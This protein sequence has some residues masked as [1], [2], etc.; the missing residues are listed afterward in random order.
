MRRTLLSTTTLATA[1][2]TAYS[3]NASADNQVINDLGAVDENT[4][5]L[6]Q[7]SR[8]QSDVTIVAEKGDSAYLL[9]MSQE[10]NPNPSKW[11]SRINDAWGAAG[12]S[13]IPSA[14]PAMKSVEHENREL[15]TSLENSVVNLIENQ[16]SQFLVT[17]TALSTIPKWEPFAEFVAKIGDNR[18]LGQVDLFAPLVQDGSSMIFSNIRGTFS[19]NSI[20][21]GNFGLGYRQIVPGGFFGLDSIFG[22]YGF[23]DIRDTERGNTFRQAT[24][25][26][27]LITESLEF[28]V[29]G[30][31][32]E[33]KKFNVGGVGAPVGAIILNGV[34]VGIAG[35]G[36]IEQALPGFDVEAG[37]RFELSE[38]AA[39]RLNAGY[40]RFE[41]DGTRVE[42]GMARAELEFDDPF[43]W[44]GAKFSI[45]GEVRDDNLRGTQGY[46]LARL[47]IPLQAGGTINS[48]TTDR[49]ELQGIDRFMTR[50]IY[51]DDDIVTTEVVDPNAFINLTDVA[52]GETLQVFHVAETPQ[53]V[54]DCS[55]VNN[56]CTVAAAQALAGA[57]DTFL[58]VDVAGNI[59]SAIAL[60]AD[61]QK[62][63]GSGNNGAVAIPMTD[64]L[65][66]ILQLNNLGGRPTVSG[67]NF[68]NILNPTAVGFSTNTATGIQGNGFTGQA[69]IGDIMSTNGG[70]NFQNSAAAINVADSTFSGGTNFGILL[71]NLTGQTTFTNVDVFGGQG[72]GI[73][74]VGGTANA[75]FD[76]TSTLAQNGNGPAVDVAGGHTGTFTFNGNINATNGSGL[77][78]D[79][80]DGTYDFAGPTFLNGGDA[81]IDILNGSAG[82]FTFTDTDITNPT[83]AAVNIDGGSSTTTFG[84]ASSIFQSS[85]SPTVN[86]MGGHAGTFTF[87]GDLNATNGSGLQFDN[88]DGTYNFNGQAILNGGDAGID[89]LNGSA[90]TFTFADTRISN[91][92]GTAVN[93]DG[94]SS[95]TTFGATSSISQSSDSPTV[96]IAGGHT[97]AFT[98]NGNI[99]ATNGNGLQFDNADGTYNFAGPTILNG[100]DAGIDILNDSSGTFTFTDTDI[101]NPTGTAVN[102]DGGSST[103]TFGSDSSITHNSA[104]PT[105]NIAGG[106]TGT[107]TFDG[108]INATSGTGLQFDNADGTYNFNGQA[109]LNGGDAGIDIL[110]GSAGT[111]T[112]TDTRIIDPT[113]TGV[114]V[115][116]GTSTVTFGAASSISQSS[117]SPT[118]N[119]SGGHSGAFTFN[120][121]INATN[122]SGLQFDNA[123]GTYNFAGM[124]TLN[125]GDAGIDILNDSAGTFTFADTDITN[126]TGTA[127]NVDG[128]SSTATFGAASFINQNSASPTI[129]IAGGHTGTFTFDGIINATNGTGLQF[130]NADGT[131]NFVGQTILNGGDAGIDILNNSDGT[132]TFTNTDITNPTGTS[133]NVDGGSSTATFSGG[134]SIAHNSANPTIN[135]AGGHTGAFTFNGVVSSTNGT[136]LQFD[137]ADGTYNFNGQITLNGGDSGI[138]ILNGSDGTFTFNSPTRITNDMLAG[139]GVFI[140]GGSA[141]TTFSGGLDVTANNGT[142]LLVVNNTGLTSLQ[143]GA[144]VNNINAVNGPAIAVNNSNVNLQ[145]DQANSTNSVVDGVLLFNLPTTAIVN[146]ASSTIMNAAQDGIEINN[147]GGTITFSNTMLNNNTNDGVAVEGGNANITFNDVSIT[148]TGPTDEGIDIDDFTGIF[149]INTATIDQ[150]GDDGLDVTDSNGTFNF[151]SVTITNTAD[152]GIDL[153][154]TLGTV[155]FTGTTTVNNSGEEGISIDAAT[156][157]PINFNGPVNITGAGIDGISVIGGNAAVNFQ[158]V[159][160]NGPLG[161]EGVFFDNY[162]GTAN[163]NGTT[164]VTGAN[165]DG[166]NIVDSSG[167]FNFNTV[168]ITNADDIAIELENTSGPISF[169]AVTATNSGG[170][171]VV[172]FGPT[173][174]PINFTGPLVIN[175]AGFDGIG[176][177]GGNGTL[178]FQ[179]VTLNGFFGVDGIFSNGFGGTANFAGTTTIDG[180][181]DDGIDIRGN[182]GTFTFN[183]ID[184]DNADDNGIELGGNTGAFNVN[185]G[186]IDNVDDDAIDITNSNASFNSVFIGDAAGSNIGDDAVDV[187]NDDA[188][189]RTFSFMNG[190]IGLGA[191]SIILDRGITVESTGTGTLDATITTTQIQSI[192]QAIFASSGANANS[193]ILDLSDNGTL[194]R[195]NAGG[196]TMEI[197]GGALNSTIVKTLGAGT[198]QLIGGNGGGVLFNQVTFDADGNTGNGIQ[199]AT[200]GT[201]IIGSGAGR[202][203]GDGLSFLGPTGD[204]GFTQLTIFNNAGTGLE[205]DTKLFGGTTFNLDVAGGSIDTTGGPSEGSIGTE[206]VAWPSKEFCLRGLVKEFFFEDSNNNFGAKIYVCVCVCTELFLLTYVLFT[207]MF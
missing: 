63:F 113:G 130:D 67:V 87:N 44:Q 8:A 150:A 126:P 175:G 199:Q 147:S 106:H 176:I 42:G 143:T 180:V 50:R 1:A 155:N 49:V 129:N 78:F 146:V 178:N 65:N 104:N 86:I 162:S 59:A 77:Q 54:A 69:T 75:T 187:L 15:A 84:A 45:G 172:F 144:V 81:G 167:T 112:F 10:E 169:G 98:F 205:V 7:I 195:A 91:P 203:Q 25:G 47:R 109:I 196:F 159:T 64:A 61:N 46:G 154:G 94:G 120:G 114:N 171:G 14:Q 40:Y 3:S 207:E 197:A 55:N 191:G 27:E 99:N 4:A 103:T 52:T 188:T 93:V 5:G 58:A 202:V 11:R 22:I 110:N 206:A 166:I 48:E 6:A 39:L 186:T 23:F 156:G 165:D 111:F 193:L 62:V 21:E 16:N 26:A 51:R 19:N 82:T 80:A 119:I 34:N 140:N 17:E 2:L 30:Y 72:G 132:F 68:G 163:F 108:D 100:G 12:S 56:A 201:L 88:A 32:P 194:T 148:G 182:S 173:G 192:N 118:V 57:G 122:G 18:L 96:N 135:I 125:G 115:D 36:T 38:D 157:G 79:N 97:G 152:N 174:G 181:G 85:A 204:I 95:T 153:N 116:G 189:N 92:T 13:Y 102:V 168:N 184:I 90:G 89:I 20:Q 198:T 164:S 160:I 66:S 138:D 28:R 37:V 60:N 133:V 70:L 29:N 74:L 73:G 145:V 83:G 24:I 124:T 33:D 107:F 71:Q 31:F 128:G 121:N 35:N 134:S 161:F 137:N 185:G 9:D 41:R 179:D 177:I 139:V 43:G 142:G 190:N 123:D 141:N 200:G 105:V 76:A 131:Y 170:A 101:T 149:N 136:G 183:N 151:N 158:D 127:V 53:G 117:D